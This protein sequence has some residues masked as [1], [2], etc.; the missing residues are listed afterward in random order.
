MD[1]VWF[2]VRLLWLP[3][4]FTLTIGIIAGIVKLWGKNQN[5]RAT[6]RQ[7]VVIS[8]VFVA[9][10]IAFV[11]FIKSASRPSMPE[12]YAQEYPPN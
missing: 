3:V 10:L 12:E 6:P 1:W 4:A 8:L 9:V 7:I 11:G 5:D 2:L